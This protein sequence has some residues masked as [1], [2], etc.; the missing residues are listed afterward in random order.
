MSEKS[1]PTARG[2]YLEKFYK[3]TEEQYKALLGHQ[4]NRCAICKRAFVNA[5]KRFRPCVDHCH[6]TGEVRG[7]LCGSCNLGIGQ[8]FDS[9]ILLKKAASYLKK[10]EE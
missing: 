3:M 7:I 9:P 6:A 4:D 5:A 8:F 2:Q 1:K 10:S